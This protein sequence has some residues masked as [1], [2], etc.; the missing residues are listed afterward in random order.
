MISADFQKSSIG[1]F[2]DKIFGIL[3]GVLFGI[4]ILSLR[5]IAP[6][7]IYSGKSEIL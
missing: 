3:Y 1:N 4:I 6:K 5:M 2:F 7:Q